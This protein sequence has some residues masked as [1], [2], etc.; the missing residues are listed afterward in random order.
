MNE[1][2]VIDKP[3]SSISNKTGGWRAMRPVIDYKKCI[4]CGKCWL[5]CPA[6]AIFSKK[7]KIT[8][9]YD[10]CKGCGICTFECPVKA[11]AMIKEEK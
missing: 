2:A 11:I 9:D 7:G 6:V 1:G 8:I 3:G 5:Q 4:N 10:F